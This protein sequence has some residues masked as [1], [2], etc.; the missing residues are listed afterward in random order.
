MAKGI[1]DIDVEVTGHPYLVVRHEFG[2]NWGV[3]RL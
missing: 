1:R 2:R 3:T